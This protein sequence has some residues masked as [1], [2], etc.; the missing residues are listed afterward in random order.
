MSH[1]GLSGTSVGPHTTFLSRSQDPITVGSKNGFNVFP[2]YND[3]YTILGP[4][5]LNK[6]Y[7]GTLGPRWWPFHAYHICQHSMFTNIF[8]SIR[9]RAMFGPSVWAC[10]PQSQFRFGSS[11]MHPCGTMANPFYSGGLTPPSVAE[12]FVHITRRR[13]ERALLGAVAGEAFPCVL[14]ML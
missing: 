7:H 10:G 2:K 11:F 3:A 8:V 14:N 12:E 5:A 9:K 4:C 1:W 6:H 13:K